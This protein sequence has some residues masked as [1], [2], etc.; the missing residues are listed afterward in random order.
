MIF[1]L[2][3]QI[4][5][6]VIDRCINLSSCYRLADESNV[7]KSSFQRLLVCSF[8]LPSRSLSLFFTIKS[9]ASIALI[10]LRKKVAVDAHFISSVVYA[11]KR[12]YPFL[13]IHTNP[14]ATVPIDIVLIDVQC[15][16]VVHLIN[17]RLITV[18]AVEHH[19]RD[20]MEANVRTCDFILQRIKREADT[21]FLSAI[22]SLRQPDSP[23]SRQ[24]NIVS[25]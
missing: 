13:F 7:N 14:F 22:F 15:V 3:K 18:V 10:H 9:N 1:D 24:F 16:C 11:R 25:R 5:V 8:V 20:A 12:D 17:A 2:S 21:L 6:L 4:N 19:R 23:K